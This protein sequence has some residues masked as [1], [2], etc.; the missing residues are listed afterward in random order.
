MSENKHKEMTEIYSTWGDKLLQHTDVLS[1]IQNEQKFKPITIQLACNESC[2]ST[3]PFCSVA[4]RPLKSYMPIEKIEKCLVD[5][6][7]LGAKSLELTGGGEPLI[8]KDKKSS[9]NINDIISYA[10]TLKYNIGIITNSHDLKYIKPENYSKIDWLRI[11]L[12]K[13]D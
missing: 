2:S 4:G 1:S 12:I 11:S 3:C 6:K 8:Y 10:H 5:F 7:L 13:L 9:K